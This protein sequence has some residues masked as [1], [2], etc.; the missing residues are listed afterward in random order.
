MKIMILFFC[1]FPTLAFAETYSY[2]CKVVEELSLQEDGRLITK[3]NNI[4]KNKTFHVDRNTG[5]VLGGGLGNSSYKTKTI[6]DPGGTQQSFKLIWLSH[7]VRGTNNKGKNAV[8][9][10]VQE[11]Y[12]TPEKPFVLVTGFTTLSGICK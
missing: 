3:K 5:T 2:E 6:L 9:L 7:P 4:Y 12:E 11:F 8:Y 10:L 1:L